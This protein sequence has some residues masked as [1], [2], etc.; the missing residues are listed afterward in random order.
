[1]IHQ[2]YMAMVIG[3][4]FI[5]SVHYLSLCAV[6]LLTDNY[7]YMRCRKATMDVLNDNRMYAKLLMFLS[8]ADEL[9]EG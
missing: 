8:L 6:I 1:M 7:A 4:M 2:S 3:T 9:F 5:S